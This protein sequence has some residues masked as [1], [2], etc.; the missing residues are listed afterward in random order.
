[1]ILGL[2]EIL[3]VVIFVAAVLVFDSNT[4]SN[5]AQSYSVVL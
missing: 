3:V 4:A 2:G 1:M 5:I